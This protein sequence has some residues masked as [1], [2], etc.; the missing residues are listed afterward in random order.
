MLEHRRARRSTN[1]E[2]ETSVSKITELATSQ[3]TATDTLAIELV[4]AD[5]NPAVVI[6]SWPA[7]PA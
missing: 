5:E 2:S 7:K 1:L 4:E 6:I 3:I